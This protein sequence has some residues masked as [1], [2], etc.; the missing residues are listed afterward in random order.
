MTETFYVFSLLLFIII[1]IVVVA[2]A[3]DDDYDGHD[4]DDDY[5]DKNVCPGQGDQTTSRWAGGNIPEVPSSRRLL[6]GKSLGIVC[7]LMFAINIISIFTM[8]IINNIDN[9]QHIIYLKQNAKLKWF[10]TIAL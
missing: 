2:A 3:A 10:F 5:D 4:D 9:Y 8:I 1:I 6:R 7:K